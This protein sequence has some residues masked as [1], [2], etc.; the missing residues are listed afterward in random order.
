MNLWGHLQFFEKIEIK[1]LH[2]ASTLT[3]WIQVKR[4]RQT[5]H[6]YPTQFPSL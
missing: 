3:S 6:L 5:F 4:K 2:L 1:L